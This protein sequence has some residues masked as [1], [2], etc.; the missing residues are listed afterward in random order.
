LPRKKLFTALGAT[1]VASATL[2]GVI[3][4]SASAETPLPAQLAS[5]GRP[6]TPTVQTEAG[7]DGATTPHKAGQAT[8][9]TAAAPSGSATPSADAGADAAPSATAAPTAMPSGASR[10]LPGA[11]VY[12]QASKT[13]ISGRASHDGEIKIYDEVGRQFGATAPVVDGNWSMTIPQ[14]TWTGRYS[15]SVGLFVDGQYA[16]ASYITLDWTQPIVAN[17]PTSPITGSTATLSG[18]GT[19]NAQIT[20]F[21]ESEVVAETK[22]VNGAWSVDLRDITVGRHD[23]TV[24][25]YAG[26]SATFHTVK[27]IREAPTGAK[28]AVEAPADP[29]VG[30]VPGAAFTFTGS[31][32][33]AARTVTIRNAQGTALAVVPVDA[34][35]ATWS[36]TRP[37]MGTSTYRLTFVSDEGTPDEQRVLLG[38]FAPRA[39]APAE[40]P[41]MFTDPVD[42]AAG[43]VPNSAF[44]F[45]GKA[46]PGASVTLQNAQGVVF[47]SG[48]PVD[49]NGDWSWTR[50]NMGTSIWKITAVATSPRGTQQTS[51]TAF[52]PVRSTSEAHI[53]FTDPRDPTLG[54][55]ANTAFTFRGTAPQGSRVMLQ[56]DKGIV[57]AKD[58]A[59]DENGAWS[60]TRANMGTSIWKITAVASLAGGGQ[61]SVTL[62]PFAPAD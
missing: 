11:S 62:A 20:V 38:A 55:P 4:P 31:A 34:T 14:T 2:T 35:T 32:P 56:N 45:R 18:T 49:K 22:A 15:L 9:S 33:A 51:L 37:N 5:V 57:F 10:A 8:E 17:G 42:S 30:Y 59:V 23:Y 24:M 13:T 29:H 41:V 12:A 46:T 1:I 36:W 48:I 52:A 54:Y 16:A 44:T 43:Y 6:S 21:E 27:V 25:N 47:A 28:L 40:Q 3:P 58:I 7:P 19:A 39:E 26:G 50:A 60:W 53:V 61:Q